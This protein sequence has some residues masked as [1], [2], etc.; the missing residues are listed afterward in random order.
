MRLY[1]RLIFWFV[2]ANVVAIVVAVF[3]SSQMWARSYSQDDAEADGHAAVQV[4]E[5]Q[6]REALER[7]LR[8]RRKAG[9]FGMLADARGEPL[10]RGRSLRHR[11]P[12]TAGGESEDRVRMRV[13]AAAPGVIFSIG[14]EDHVRIARVPSASGATYEWRAF[15]APPHGRRAHL[16][17][18]ALHTLIGL[19]VIAGVAILAARQIKRPIDG[20][21][22]A[23]IA[24]ASGRLRTRVPD[25]IASR[26]DELG[27][28]GRSFNDMA[29]RLQRLLESQRQL[30]RD[31]SHELRSPL[32]RLRIASELARGQPSGA[33]FDR[34]E[35][36]AA[37][38]DELIGQVLLV[39][40]L[41][42]PMNPAARSDIDV[43][44]LVEQVCDDAGLEAAQRGVDIDVRVEGGAQVSGWPEL[45]R[46]A[47]E[48]VVR[49]AVRY[50]AD[51]TRIEVEARRDAAQWRIVVS[52]RGPG[53]PEDQLAEIFKPFHR[54]SSARERESGGYGL[55]LAIA[56]RAVAAHG[57][58]I[59][60]SNVAEGGLCVRISVPISGTRPPA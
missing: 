29:A 57:G 3:V 11:G 1:G 41:D 33:H 53:V 54:V 47:L 19:L 60:A 9:V 32:A 46:S 17:Q 23:T 45:L 18:V 39:A 42:A 7:W 59:T 48:N 55:G 56:E 15:S 13:L 8:Q 52:D 21:R 5:S 30:L 22:N 51:A 2:L 35:Q 12:P 43:S 36:E 24:L 14:G 34:I 20:L 49:N 28:L 37:R 16:R 58:T 44:A 50:T 25:S 6:G 38:L 26:G 10:A 4:Y 40:R 31:V 27:E